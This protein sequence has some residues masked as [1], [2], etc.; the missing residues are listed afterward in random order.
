[1]MRSSRLSYLGCTIR[2]FCSFEPKT[3]IRVAVAM[4]GGIDSAACAYILKSS[5]YDCVGVFMKNWDSSDEIG[6]MT[7]CTYS[8]DLNDMQEVCKRLDIP[9]IEVSFAQDYWTDVFQPLLN[10]YESAIETPNPDVACNRKIKFGKL[11][12]YVF[13]Q[14]NVDYLATGH[15]ARLG[16]YNSNGQLQENKYCRNTLTSSFSSLST[17]QSQ[18]QSSNSY[19][20]KDKDKNH[21][22]FP[23]LLRGID[24]SK[25]QSYFLS[26]TSGEQLENVLFP[27]GQF[28]KKEVRDIVEIPLKGLNVLTKRESMGICFI[29]KRK[30]SDFL[31]QYISFTPG[32]FIDIDTGFVLGSHNGKEVMTI[33]Q[34]ARISGAPEK[35]F[36]VG[37]TKANQHMLQEKGDVLVAKGSHHPSLYSK[38]LIVSYNDY[39]WISGACPTGLEDGI[40]VGNIH[41][42]ARYGQAAVACSIKKCGDF[43]HVVFENEQRGITPGQVCVL[44]QDDVCLGGGIIKGK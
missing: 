5:G 4:S 27:L 15:Y 25:D 1:M 24:T 3:E 33:G 36:V 19:L 31:G 39:V 30:F 14:L 40:E 13:K 10:T 9:Y 16:Y 37:I 12:D 41:V 35:Y 38:S 23:V 28:T 22:G 44:Y 6:D 29:G 20:S 42:K 21:V 7:T 32:K 26:M 18:S 2:K 34:N 17:S 8:K 11:R 43:L